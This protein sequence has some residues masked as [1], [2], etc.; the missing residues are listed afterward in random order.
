MFNLLV[1]GQ[2]S[3][4][5]QKLIPTVFENFLGGRPIDVV[6]VFHTMTQQLQ[7][8]GHLPIGSTGVGR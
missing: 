1:A 8:L 5:S 6:D 7:R 3:L 2:G 4:C